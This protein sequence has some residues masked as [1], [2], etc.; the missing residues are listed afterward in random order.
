MA[1]RRPSRA[2]SRSA[3]CPPSPAARPERDV[4]AMRHTRQVRLAEVGEAGQARVRVSALAVRGSGVA[5]AI[6]A[7]YLAGAGV[8][9]LRVRDAAQEEAARAVDGDVHVRVEEVD[10][11][12]DASAMGAMPEE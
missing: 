4:S 9:S 3:S 1:S 12:A 10:A 11:E 8:G 7:R 2:A 5:G 6:E